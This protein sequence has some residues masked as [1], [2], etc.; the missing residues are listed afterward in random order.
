MALSLNEPIFLLVRP[1]LPENIGAVARAMA[2]FGLKSLRIIDPVCDILSEKAIA[3][4]AGAEDILENACLFSSFEN[5][6]ADLHWVY[7]TCAGKRHLIKEYAPLPSAIAEIGQ[8]IKSKTKVGVL[9]GPERTGLDNSYLSRCHQIIQIPVVPSFSSLNLAQAVVLIGYEWFIKK[10]TFTPQMEYGETYPATQQTLQR[11]LD[12][13]EKDLD[14]TCYWRE[15]SKKPLM[16]QN[17]QN[18]F[19]R[20]Q[21]ADQDLRTLRGVFN[22]YKRWKN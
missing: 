16:W 6:A 7:G 15:P 21:L 11:F 18:I 17:L 19:T 9:F 8:K 13:L 3:T 20:L 10:D 14:T 1:Q 5:A 4:A 2:N 12:D 22:S